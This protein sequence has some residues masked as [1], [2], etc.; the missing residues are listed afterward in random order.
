MADVTLIIG[1]RPYQVGCADGE[2]E[3]LRHLGAIVDEQIASARLK[4]GGLTETRQ[5]LF[6][7][8]LLADRLVS[9]DYSNKKNT[10]NEDITDAISRIDE[11]SARIEAMGARLSALR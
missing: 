8:I 7:A 3:A 10:D 11:V 4:T 6:A 1:G 2:E 5:L 9:G